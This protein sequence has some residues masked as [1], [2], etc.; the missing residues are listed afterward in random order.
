MPGRTEKATSSNFYESAFFRLH[1]KYIVGLENGVAYKVLLCTVTGQFLRFR[2][3]LFL[4]NVLFI[5]AIFST[6]RQRS[7]YV[8]HQGVLTSNCLTKQPRDDWFESQ[9][10]KQQYT[11]RWYR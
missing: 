10:K 3:K 9:V 7:D 1:F 5:L 2:S 4:M 8:P 11:M 6:K